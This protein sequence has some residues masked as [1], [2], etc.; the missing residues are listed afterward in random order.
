MKI[1]LLPKKQKEGNLYFV[2]EKCGTI[3]RSGHIL[4]NLFTIIILSE[5]FKGNAVWSHLWNH[6]SM[7]EHTDLYLE[8]PKKIKKQIKINPKK[9]MWGGVSYENFT[10]LK[11]KINKHNFSTKGDLLVKLNGI[12][13]IHPCQVLNWELD[14]KIP[15]GTYEEVVKKIKGMYWGDKIKNDYNWPPKKISIHVRRG[16]VGNLS[17]K[18]YVGMGPG[19]VWNADFYQRCVNQLKEEFPEAKIK[20]HT[21]KRNSEDIQKIK[22]AE[23]IFGTHDNHKQDMEDMASADLLIPANSSFSTWLCYATNGRVRIYNEEHMKHFRH[24]KLPENFEIGKV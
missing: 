21:L 4:K 2:Y 14:N 19:G 8:K 24:N 15:K 5:I 1:H 16:D 17:N 20:I 10:D 23:I 7:F 18:E 13:R 6:Q 11:N 22:G 9:E 12:Y 3:G